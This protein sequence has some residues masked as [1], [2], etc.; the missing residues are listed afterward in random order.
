MIVDYRC[1]LSLHRAA[2]GY[3]LATDFG[4]EQKK[5]NISKMLLFA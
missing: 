3:S 4:E 5:V 2:I 1:R